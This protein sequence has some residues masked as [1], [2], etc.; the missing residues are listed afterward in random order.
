MPSLAHRYYDPLVDSGTLPLGR[1]LIRFA[2]EA[3]EA[4]KTGSP[5][6]PIGRGIAISFGLL[7]MQTFGSL[8]LNQFAYH[9][10][11]VGGQA[12][13]G[14]IGVI[15]S[16]S[17][18]ISGRARAGG[19]TSR[20][21][22]NDATATAE[23]QEKSRKKDKKNKKDGEGAGWSNGK[24]VNL[25][26][27]DSY[28]VDLA[29]SWFHILWTSFIQVAL[30]LVLLLINISVSALAGFALLVLGIPILSWVV[31]VLAAKRRAMN[32]I[33]DRRVALTQEILMRVRFVKFFA[34]EKSFLARLADLRGKEI[35][36]VQFLLG[37]RSGVNAVGMSIPVFAS[38]LAFITYSLTDNRL[39]P[40]EV[41]SSLAL[42][43]ALRMP[44]NLLP[45]VIAQT[46]DAW[47]S[48]Q[49]IQ[50]YLL[51]EET[52]DDAIISDDNPDFSVEISDGNFTWE[53]VQAE[54]KHNSDKTK[55]ELKQEGR[56]RRQEKKDDAARE[57]TGEADPDNTEVAHSL[58]PFTL[59][60]INLA[61]GR[62][63]LIA[64]VGGVG[65]G[66]SSLLAALAGEMR[67]TSGTVKRGPRVAYCPQHAWIQNAS[68]RENILFGLE[69]KESW[70]ANVVEACAL[71]Q[72]LDMLP[73]GDQTEIGERGITVSG[74]QKQRLNIAR[75]IYFDADI[76]L[77]DDPLS[78][79][80][81]HV[82]RHLFDKAIC[83][84]LKD[85]CRILVTHQ[86]HVINKVDRV[87]WMEDGHIEAVGSF[88]E[89]METN[90]GFSK[91]MGE[92]AIETEEE[93]RDG[94]VDEPKEKNFGGT[95][96]GAQA[97]ALMQGEERPVKSV[98]WK[99]YGAYIK[100]SGS[101]LNAPAVIGLLVIA[102]ACNII[103]TLWLG[104]WVS[105]MYGLSRGTYAAIFAALG[106]VQSLLMFA[107]AYSL[108]I[109]GTRSS[110]ALM[111]KAMESTL[112]APVSFF[113]TTPTGRILNRFS[114]DVD[115][116]DNS[117]TDAIRM[118]FF[119]L[120]MIVSVFILTIV[121][122]H[123]FAIALFPLSIGFV[124]AASYYRASAREVKRHEA[125]LRSVVYAKFGEALTGVACI[126]A[127]GLRDRFIAEIHKAI[128]GM[129]S[130]YF[131]TFANQ[132]WLSLRVDAICNLCELTLLQ[133]LRLANKTD[134][135][136]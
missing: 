18:R 85:K 52:K 73:N 108:T 55:A 95:G 124:F 57:K 100:A 69:F 111:H 19:T 22:L 113:D 89:L 49:R 32:Q 93:D 134:S 45:V 34:W 11:M 39:N 53:K 120:A 109:A 68:V 8:F 115:V 118:Y 64:I 116:M 44:L 92:I 82:G 122:F 35:R 14:L 71:Q 65:S 30:A 40:A 4:A 31:K 23:E 81:A 119:S 128:D 98:P 59:E 61:V 87:V 28:R 56:Q 136:V 21:T 27:T 94:E 9:G 72:D 2:V 15:F 80:D 36:A 1:Y 133:P 112:R 62:Q 126:R 60:N 20:N 16:K 12:R 54:E 110:K 50:E 25:M 76:V 90:M 33:T 13:A 117:L 7:L 88:E 130:A 51:A 66:K 78:A 104:W 29:A 67:K 17:L 102:Q 107:F 106:I 96:N 105:D 42:F 77:L 41:F 103:T 84:L 70:Y 37:V 83:G 43:N 99:V 10:M 47:V 58:A 46:I 91:M 127:Y 86:L 79:V 97:K 26:G 3:Y 123:Y 74:G 135:K 101:Y 129:N 114:K 6:P 24:V 121:Y 125:V 63:E 75:A 132:R 48:I 5:E 38:M 131:I